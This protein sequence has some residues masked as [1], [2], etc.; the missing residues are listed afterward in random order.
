MDSLERF[1]SAQARDYGTALAEIRSGHKRSHW[2]WY[3]FPQLQGLGMSSTAQYYGVRGIEEA[4]RFIAHPVLGRNLREISGALLALDTND[5]AAVMG[6]PDNLKLCSCMTLFEAAR[7]SRYSAQCWISST[8]AK[9]TVSRS[10]SSDKKYRQ[11]SKKTTAVSK[12]TAV[13][14]Y[15]AIAESYRLV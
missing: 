14:L 4:K 15:A 7:M 11:T 9:E 12:E 5:P 13:V 6:W 10:K 3:I 2:M 1:V 8:A